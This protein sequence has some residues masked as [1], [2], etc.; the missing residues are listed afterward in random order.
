[1][2]F[3]FSEFENIIMDIIDLQISTNE[4]KLKLENN[5]LIEYKDYQPIEMKFDFMVD[6]DSCKASFNKK[7]SCLNLILVRKDT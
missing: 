1:V 4:I 3:D 6:V 2:K 5:E 7:D